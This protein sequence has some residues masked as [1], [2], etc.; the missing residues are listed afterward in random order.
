MMDPDLYKTGK[1][2]TQQSSFKTKKSLK[3]KK[4]PKSPFKKTEK[5]I[6]RS[7]K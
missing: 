4:L 2:P 1:Q 5:R 6:L 3:Q 7:V